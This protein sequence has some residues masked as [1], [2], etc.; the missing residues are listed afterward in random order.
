[1]HNLFKVVYSMI[2]KSHLFPIQVVSAEKRKE[3]K[4]EIQVYLGL[5]PDGFFPI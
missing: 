4:K 1:M 3:I 2:E 5:L